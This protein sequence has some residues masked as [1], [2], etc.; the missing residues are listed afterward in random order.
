MKLNHKTLWL[1]DLDGT[2][3][4]SQEGIAFST[5]ITLRKFANTELTFFELTELFGTPIKEVFSS[6]I[7]LEL[8]EEAFE[9]YQSHLLN[10]AIERMSLFAGVK[11]TLETLRSQGKTLKIITNK[12]TNLAIRI[13]EHFRLGDFFIEVFGSDLAKPKP[14]PDLIKLALKNH[15]REESVIVGDRIEDIQ[16]GIAAGITTILVGINSYENSSVNVNPDY[17]LPDMLS[18]LNLVEGN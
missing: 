10:S 5:N 4:D 17:H 1:F 14:S 2:L 7:P 9:F 13:L 3:I 16:A 15:N 12:H 11:E 8:L 18:L 6:Q